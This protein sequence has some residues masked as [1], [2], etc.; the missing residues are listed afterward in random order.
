[1][2]KGKSNKMRG[3]KKIYKKQLFNLCKM[4]D[5]V[6]P[7]DFFEYFFDFVQGIEN[8]TIWIRFNSRPSL[9]CLTPCGRAVKNS[10]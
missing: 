4:L 5:F 8:V 3:F 2:A 6:V 9:I 10:R 1:M 7:R